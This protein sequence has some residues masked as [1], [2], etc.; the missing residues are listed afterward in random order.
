MKDKLKNMNDTASAMAAIAEKV[1][2]WNLLAGAV[3]K[4]VKSVNSIFA[5]FRSELAVAEFFPNK[6]TG[7]NFTDFAEILRGVWRG[8]VCYEN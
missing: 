7:T 8:G 1:T 6:K 5:A 2:R 3:V 4:S